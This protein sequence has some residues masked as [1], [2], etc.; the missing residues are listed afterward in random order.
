MSDMTSF[1]QLGISQDA[2]LERMTA[3]E[4]KPH[5][6][7]QAGGLF[8]NKS[9]QEMPTDEVRAQCDLVMSGEFCAFYLAAQPINHFDKETG[10]WK[11][12][13]TELLLRA[14][15][16]KQAFP[17]AVV[18]H[19]T[20]DQRE[21]LLLWQL[22]EAK[23]LVD[24][25]RSPMV[26]VN[27]W[28]QDLYSRLDEVVELIHDTSVVIEVTEY[29]KQQ[30]TV[31]F[32]ST[33]VA[34]DLPHTIKVVTLLRQRG[35]LVALDDVNALKE[36]YPLNAAAALA[37]APFVPII[38]M[39]IM[40]LMRLYQSVPMAW[41]PDKSFKPNGFLSKKMME[42]GTEG[43]ERDR[44]KV[45]E[46]VQQLWSLNPSLRIVVE[47]SVTSEEI[48]NSFAEIGGWGFVTDPRVCIQ[49]GKTHDWA[50]E[51]VF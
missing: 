46:F 44:Q 31:G 41:Q 29:T 1:K 39:D 42:E 32:P 35:V 23:K 9:P 26:T 13:G 45:A 43:L 10:E 20:A 2:L 28:L 30:D 36:G 47:L 14:R 6:H 18:Y 15:D 25:R 22:R 21:R 11:L 33:S 38:K 24:S 48:A 40:M 16:G 27:A 12:A 19:A 49:G 3:E 51:V 34:L 7:Y 4:I 37:V 50:E 5:P 17:T 8:F